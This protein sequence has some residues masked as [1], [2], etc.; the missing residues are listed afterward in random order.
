MVTLLDDGA[1]CVHLP[2][3]GD[4]PGVSD[5]EPASAHFADR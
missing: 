2:A 5:W 3:V 4:I 1:L